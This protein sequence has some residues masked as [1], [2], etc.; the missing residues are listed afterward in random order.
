MCLVAK[1]LNGYLQEVISLY[2]EQVALT[3]ILK[4]IVLKDK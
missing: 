2:Y 1:Q 3:L 4:L